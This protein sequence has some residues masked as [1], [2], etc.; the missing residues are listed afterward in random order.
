[1]SQSFSTAP[2]EAAPNL[3]RLQTHEVESWIEA[4][5]LA[6]VGETRHRV[7]SSL[8]KLIASDL[9]GQ[10]RYA[11]LELFRSPIHYLSE[12]L[13]HYFVGASIPLTLRARGV[14]D[15]LSALH[16]AMAEGYQG[17]ADEL[18]G[19]NTVRQDFM[20]LATSLHRS[21]YYLGQTLL[22]GYQLYEPCSSDCWRRIHRIYEAA[23]RKGVHSSTVR[24]PYRQ[25]RQSTTIEEQ[26]KQILLLALTD[27]YRHSQSDIRSIYS[28]LEYW[29]PQCRLYPADHADALQSAWR[30]D[31]ASDDPPSSNA[32]SALSHPATRRFLDTSALIQSL[33]NSLPPS[34]DEASNQAPETQPPQ[35]TMRWKDLLR[36]LATAWGP[37]A[38]RRYSRMHPETTDIAISLG[39]SA[40]HP[41]L[42]KLD[43]MSA[44]QSAHIGR[45]STTPIAIDDKDS[46]L[47]KVMDESAGGS[48][49]M[50][51]NINK[52]KI[53]VGELIAL[54]QT[55]TPGEMPGI[56]AIRWLKN[57]SKQTVEFGIQL[58]S[59]DAFP[60]TVRLYT[61]DDLE[62]D[63]DYLKGL[64]IPE[65]KAIRQP[66]SLILP[67]FL[68]CADDVIS[69]LM[70][71]Q[72]H[73]IQLA[74]A[75]ETTQGFSRF[76]FS[77][78][79]TP[80]NRH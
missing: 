79:A 61:A 38:K 1:M 4:L 21:L 67:A 6:D 26:Y 34:G 11:A 57:T 56:A 59:P 27:P 45:G 58:L 22:T 25:H 40:I 55:R 24:D 65:F 20:M 16:M 44:M 53:R 30:I 15:Q 19:L 63:H 8:V 36:S 68:Y 35:T 66:A 37:T 51:R 49:L 78:L 5:P 76:Y 47:C 43:S 62:S 9:P 80:Q 70:D 48:R 13:Q 50:W 23:E 74:K 42:D 7:S 33:P 75:I 72:E 18:L 60:I 32:Y 64:Y 46:Y 3:M 10:E 71:H 2:L 39:L 41:L 28:L 73:C 77:S 69:L 52:G 31:L 12:A 54:H 17:L 14:A 29:T